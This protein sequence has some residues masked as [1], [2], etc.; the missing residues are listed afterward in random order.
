MVQGPA[1]GLAALDTL[2]DRLSGHYRLAAVRGHFHEM[3]GN[4]DA[5]V[6]CYR[7]AAS[8]TTSEPERDYLTAQAARLRRGQPPA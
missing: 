3:A 8:R 2:E 5:A 6:A 4:S 1:A 7:T